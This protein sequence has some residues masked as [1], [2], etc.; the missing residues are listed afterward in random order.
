MV[1]YFMTLLAFIH[2]AVYA[3]EFTA[4][5]NRNP[6]TTHEQFTLNLTLKDASAQDS[7][8]LDLLDEMFTIKGQQ[9]SSNM[10]IKN[11]Q[12]HSSVTWKVALVPHKE[13]TIIIPPLT[14]NTNQGPLK[15]NPI[16]L[17][18]TQNNTQTSPQTTGVVLTTELT[19]N[20]PYKNQ[21]LFYTLRLT[22][23]M[24]M[25]N[26][27]PPKFSVEEALV[28]QNGEPKASH[29]ML[30]GQRVGMI[31]FN[32]IITP[33]KAGGVKIPSIKVEGDIQEMERTHHP[34]YF[35]D[36]F[37][38]FFNF[39]PSYRL[40]P[41]QVLSEEIVLDVQP[42]RMTPWIP[43]KNFKIEEEWDPSQSLKV[44]D[45]I[46][47]GFKMS[48]EGL[49][50]SQL[51]SLADQ[52]QK[53]EASFKFYADKPELD[54]QIEGRNIRSTRKEQYTL[55]PK[56]AGEVTL[57]AMQVEWWDVNSQQKAKAVIPARTL[58]IAASEASDAPA[59]V[60][61]TAAVEQATQE[62]AAGQ[63]GQA[64]QTSHHRLLYGI[65]IVQAVLLAAC[66]CWITVLTR[67]LHRFKEKRRAQHETLPDL[68]PT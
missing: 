18:V 33:L 12:M 2:V 43:A 9:Q 54:S 62:P 30:N 47:R 21:P 22:S 68:N 61:A 52:L 36:D 38:A 19:Q 46:V 37:G 6:V 4:A 44:G 14:I 63:M 32:Y 66:L 29:S 35:D 25:A 10:M 20:K 15:S 60:L 42:A 31:E 17:V 23:K 11:G 59:S 24:G 5:V 50:A 39:H 1:K 8:Q 55:I 58:K 26:V 3:A 56:K 49:M 7:P 41:F 34:S 27:K 48:A 65:I 57:P 16:N 64:E 67:K 28:E 45:P 51:P 13:G 53:A 40:K